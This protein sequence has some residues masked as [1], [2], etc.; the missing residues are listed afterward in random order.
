MPVGTVKKRKFPT[1]SREF[2]QDAG[3]VEVDFTGSQTLVSK[4]FVIV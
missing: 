2:G 3:Q 1:N 4:V